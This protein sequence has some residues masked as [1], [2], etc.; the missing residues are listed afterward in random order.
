VK[1]LLDHDV[2]E[3]LSYLLE[4][5]G[6]HVTLLR[7][8]LPTDASDE[9]VLRL[10]HERGCVLLTCNREDFL[11]LAAKNP[12]NGVIV[13]IRRRTRTAERAALLDSWIALG[14]LDSATLTSPDLAAL[15]TLERRT[16]TIE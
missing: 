4:Q 2:P 10:A 13:V 16:A 12:H 11:D 15:R 14:R 5:L 9:A 8:A 3:D 1:F 7:N 6:H